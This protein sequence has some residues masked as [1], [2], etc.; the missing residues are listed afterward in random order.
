MSDNSVPGTMQRPSGLPETTE[1]LSFVF[2]P[3]ETNCYV[4]VDRAIRDE[5]GV[6]PAVVVDPGF[7]AFATLSKVAEEAHFRVEKVVLTHGHI[8]HQRD[9]GLFEVPVHVHELDESFLVSDL[10]G[11]PFAQL[12]DLENKRQPEQIVHLDQQISMG[13]T[14][15]NVHHMPGHSPGH[16]MFRVDG[17][18]IGGDVLFTNGVGRTDLPLSSPEDMM[19]SLKRLV[20]DFADDDVVLTGHGLSTTIGQEKAVNPYLQAVK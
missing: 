6:S 18:I 16:V 20:T 8:D 7:G 5:A 19:L 17:L 15:W 10:S 2:G 1:I 4:L 11:S 14:V 12:F 3:L 13:G 9:A